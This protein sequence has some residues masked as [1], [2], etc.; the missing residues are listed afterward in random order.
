MIRLFL[1]NPKRMDCELL[2][3]V[4]QGEKDIEVVG[5]SHDPEEALTKIRRKGCDTVLADINLPGN[6]A[7]NIARTLQKNG[8]EAKVLI[9]GL[10]RSKS[11]ILHCIEEGVAGYVLED[12]SLAVLVKK[13]RA[14]HEEEFIVSP[15]I[16]SALMARVAELKEMANQLNGVDLSDAE[17]FFTEITPREWEVLQL[18]DK[19]YNNQQIAEKLVIEKGTVKNHVHN[20][21]SKL[22]VKSREQAAMLMRQFTQYQ[23]ENKEAPKNETKYSF[24]I[25]NPSV[26]GRPTKLMAAS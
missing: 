20:I 25:F 9:G 19:E 10:V 4:L 23:S 21:L 2:A 22:N 15:A 6:G 11:A 13:I 3:S 14:A 24:P 12:D 1:V 26:N 7:L 8:N 17:E 16:A 5:Y 18:I